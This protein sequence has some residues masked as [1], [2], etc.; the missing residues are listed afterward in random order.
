M[1]GEGEEEEE[2]VDLS[3]EAGLERQLEANIAV[4]YESHKI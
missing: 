4:R 1:R 3:K 2:K